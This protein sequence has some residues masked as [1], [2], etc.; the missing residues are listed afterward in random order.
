MA[1]SRDN[2]GCHSLGAGGVAT[3]HKCSDGWRPRVLPDALRCFV[4]SKERCCPNAESL[5]EGVPFYLL[6]PAKRAA[7]GGSKDLQ[8]VRPGHQAGYEAPEPSQAP[9]RARDTG[10]GPLRCTRLGAQLLGASGLAGRWLRRQAPEGRPG[11]SS[12]PCRRLAWGP[13]PPSCA[14]GVTHTRHRAH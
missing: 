7:E 11:I 2:L 10:P 4:P 8:G 14:L 13:E 9:Q 6:L 12:W 5:H 3:R 1:K